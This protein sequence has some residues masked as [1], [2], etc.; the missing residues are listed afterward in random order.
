MSGGAFN[1]A[2]SD[3]AYSLFEMFLPRYTKETFSLSKEARAHGPFDDRTLNERLW[4]LLCLV[5][6]YDLCVSG[7]IGE[8]EWLKIKRQFHDKWGLPKQSYQEE[9]IEDEARR[10]IAE[11]KGK[12]LDTD[13]EAT[14]E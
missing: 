13:G 12:C 10:I 11:L 1:Y 14:E 5:H 7:D 9:F 6:V 4:D 8:E 3:A 2:E